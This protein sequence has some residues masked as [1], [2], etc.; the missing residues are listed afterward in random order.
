MFPLVDKMCEMCKPWGF[1]IAA[2]TATE[3]ALTCKNTGTHPEGY[4]NEG[5]YEWEDDTHPLL[6]KGPN[7][8]DP[9]NGHKKI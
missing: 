9:N 6:A 1:K 7:A 2:E 3:A 5:N 8:A 4:N